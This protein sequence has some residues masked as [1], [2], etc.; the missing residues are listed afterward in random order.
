MRGVRQGVAPS[1]P[2]SMERQWTTRATTR[3]GRPGRRERLGLRSTDG[4][5]GSRSLTLPP[6]RSLEMFDGEILDRT[7]SPSPSPISRGPL[8]FSSSPPQG[9]HF[10][11]HFPKIQAFQRHKFLLTSILQHTNISFPSQRRETYPSQA[12]KPTKEPE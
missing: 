7:S 8:P 12:N 6:G 9:D 11:C 5:C 10:P 4:D 2:A 1:S 3:S